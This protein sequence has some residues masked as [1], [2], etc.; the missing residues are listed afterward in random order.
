MKRSRN[1]QG[2]LRADTRRQAWYAASSL[3]LGLLGSVVVFFG[4]IW[5][6]A[7]AV[8]GV[9]LALFRLVSSFADRLLLMECERAGRLLGIVIDCPPSDPVASGNVFGRATAKAR[10]VS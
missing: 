7:F 6:V 2:L 10:T 3:A 9:G 8:F 5:S 4:L 1:W